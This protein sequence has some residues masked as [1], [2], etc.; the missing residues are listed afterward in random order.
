[1]SNRFGKMFFP[2]MFPRCEEPARRAGRS[3][4]EW[5]LDPR[6][7]LPSLEGK[8]RTMVACLLLA[9]VG[10]SVPAAGG[11]VCV[12]LIS[13]IFTGQ[14]CGDC[15]DDGGDAGR[16]DGGCWVEFE[17]IP[18]APVEKPMPDVPTAPVTQVAPLAV[19][20]PPRMLR[21][22]EGPASNPSSIRGPTP[23]SIRQAILAIWRL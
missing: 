20:A 13:M 5:F 2:L 8:M 19:P 6:R 23:A 14:D 1:V 22:L 21:N 18:E 17:K 10:L 9:C 16:C 4:L 15:C 3:F 12:C 11:P 7:L